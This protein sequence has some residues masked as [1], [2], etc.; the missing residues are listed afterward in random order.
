MHVNHSLHIVGFDVQW[1]GVVPFFWQGLGGQAL[2]ARFSRDNVIAYR[3][4]MRNSCSQFYVDGLY[5]SFCQ[6]LSGSRNHSTQPHPS[7]SFIQY[8]ITWDYRSLFFFP[9]F[10]TIANMIVCGQGSHLKF[11]VIP[12]ASSC[13]LKLPLLFLDSMAH[14]N[15]H[16]SLILYLKV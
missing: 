13:F 2:M 9:C 16:L 1:K 10:K 5:V 11:V 6:L 8:L 14:L 4:G 3:P 12:S 7:S 15:L